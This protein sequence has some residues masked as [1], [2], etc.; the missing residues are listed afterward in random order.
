MASSRIDDFA[1]EGNVPHLP[2]FVADSLVFESSA[3]LA[4]LAKHTSQLMSSLGGL[5]PGLY[6]AVDD[7]GKSKGKA[8]ATA[9]DDLVGSL[10]DL[11]VEDCHDNRAQF[12]SILLLL[13]LVRSESSSTSAFHSTLLQLT[14]PPPTRLHPK[15]DSTPTTRQ[16]RSLLPL[17]SLSFA[18]EASRALSFER[19]DPIKYFILLEDERGSSYERIVLSWAEGRVRDRAWEVMKRAYISMGLDWACRWTGEEGDEWV[20]KKGA[21]CVDGVVRLR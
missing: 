9:I 4:I 12:A 7:T 8:K 14:S 1:L 2:L 13:Q 11:A 5:V 15:F 6:H 10:S 21:T 3:R 16:T 18:L 17:T 19:F 20:V